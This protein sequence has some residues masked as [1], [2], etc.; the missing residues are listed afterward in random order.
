MV[1]L[2]HAIVHLDVC[3][4]VTRVFRM[5]CNICKPIVSRDCAFER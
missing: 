1:R 5:N 3:D 2:S 4:L